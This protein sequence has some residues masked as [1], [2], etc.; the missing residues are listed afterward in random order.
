MISNTGDAIADGK[1][2]YKVVDKKG[3]ATINNGDIIA[4]VENP[5]AGPIVLLRSDLT[6]HKVDD[7]CD[8]YLDIEPVAMNFT[9][10]WTES[11][12]L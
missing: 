5:R 8:N 10:H 1:T 2:W 6:L 3:H 11:R 7:D 9:M 12:S 4:V